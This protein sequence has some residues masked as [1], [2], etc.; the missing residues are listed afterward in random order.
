MRKEKRCVDSYQHL[1]FRFLIVSLHISAILFCSRPPPPTSSLSPLRT[2]LIHRFLGA[3]QLTNT[4]TLALTTPQ[5]LGRTG[6]ISLAT[7]GF[8]DSIQRSTMMIAGAA[9]LVLVVG[10]VKVQNQR[11]IMGV[12]EVSAVSFHMTCL[13]VHISTLTH[14]WCSH[15]F[16]LSLTCAV[17]LWPFLFAVDMCSLDSVCTLEHV[18]FDM[19]SFASVL[20]NTLLLTCVHSTMSSRPPCVFSQDLPSDIPAPNPNPVA[21]VPLKAFGTHDP[22][23]VL[24]QAKSFHLPPDSHRTI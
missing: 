23:Y 16:F 18:A 22:A 21:P 3:S 11:R 17:I 7:L 10:Y 2:L 6:K 12:Y 24:E 5:P 1:F 4:P 13:R 20:F 19:S 15:D 9:A 8:N 14:F